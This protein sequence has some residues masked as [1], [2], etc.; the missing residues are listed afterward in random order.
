[1]D[2]RDFI[3]KLSSSESFNRESLATP[4]NQMG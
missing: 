2:Q 1:M 3:R 4:L